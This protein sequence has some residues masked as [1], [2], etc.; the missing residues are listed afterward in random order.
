LI[1]TEGGAA[2]GASIV[3]RKPGESFKVK[4]TS[5]STDRINWAVYAE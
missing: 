2:I 4:A 3:E 5:A 1:T